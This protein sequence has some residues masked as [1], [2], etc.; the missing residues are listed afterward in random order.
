MPALGPNRRGIL[1]QWFALVGAVIAIAAIV[2]LIVT[3]PDHGH[4]TVREPAKG[5]TVSKQVEKGV[6]APSAAVAPRN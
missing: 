3:W 6:P 2:A 1:G 5:P 4:G